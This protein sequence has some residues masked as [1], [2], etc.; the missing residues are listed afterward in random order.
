MTTRI[1]TIV[2]ASTAAIFV[3]S[4][5]FSLKRS[6]KKKD[7]SIG[8]DFVGIRL[9]YFPRSPCARRIWLLLKLR[10]IKFQGIV[11]DLMKGE[12]RNATYLQLNPLGEVPV[13]VHRK[14]QGGPLII[15]YESAAIAAYIENEFGGGLWD[16]D[17]EQFIQFELAIAEIVW[18]LS[19]AQVDGVIWRFR[20]SRAAFF[21]KYRQNTYHHAKVR[22]IYEAKH[23][24]FQDRRHRMRRCAQ[25][26]K[27]LDMA[28]GHNLFFRLQIQKKITYAH[29]SLYSRLIKI[30]QNG[31]FLKK[32]AFPQLT[33][34]LESCIPLFNN[35]G[36]AIWNSHGRPTF[37]A[38][39]IGFLFAYLLSWDLLVRIGNWRAGVDF[40]RVTQDD[41]F[42]G[43]LHQ[44]EVM[45]LQAIPR[46]YCLLSKPRLY[47]DAGHTLAAA[48]LAL[49]QQDSNIEF[50]RVDT[51]RLQHELDPMIRQVTPL[52]ELPALTTS[53]GDGYYG[54][55]VVLRALGEDYI[56][57]RER[58]I[59][60]WARTA[61]FYQIAPLKRWT[62]DQ[63]ILDKLAGDL[64]HS[65]YLLKVWGVEESQENV[66]ACAQLCSS[67]NEALLRG[68]A[69]ELWTSC[70]DTAAQLVESSSCA[71]VNAFVLPVV[72]LACVYAK[73]ILQ[74]GNNS[75][76]WLDLLAYRSPKLSVWAHK[77]L[78][79]NKFLQIAIGDLI[80][81]HT[82]LTSIPCRLGGEGPRGALIHN[83]PHPPFIRQDVV[84][85]LQ[86]TFQPE[87]SDIY[88]VT[89]PKAGTTW[90]QQIIL[91]LL[92]NGDA[93]KVDPHPKIQSQAP[94]LEACYC[95][96][97][98]WG[99]PC[100]YLDAHS[101][102][103][104]HAGRRVFK[105]HAPEEL[106][107][108][109]NKLN[110]GK[111][112]YVARNAKDTCCSL[113]SHCKTLPP[114]EYKESIDHFVPLFCQ[115]LVEHGSWRSHHLGWFNK[116]A[117]QENDNDI[118]YIHFEFLKENPNKAITR[119]A[120]FIGISHPS[121]ELIRAVVHH[122]SFAAMKQRTSSTSV[123]TLYQASTST[124][125][126]TSRFRSGAVGKWHVDNG[127]LL[128]ESHSALIDSTLL[129]D[130]PTGLLF[131]SSS[132]QHQEEE[133]SG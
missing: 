89:F 44:V 19:R 118:L 106:A 75:S 46:S 124:N 105:S 122:S 42:Q 32:N 52:G 17:L 70:I 127:G 79:E 13:L 51:A 60:G 84:D 45:P 116:A 16:F 93:T 28:C 10:N 123:S 29:L 4:S 61:W 91:L 104:R 69:T 126:A 31:L 58:Q 2:T 65:A 34:Y 115:G 14:V 87:S 66:D 131:S 36:K 48:V 59:I 71:I 120:Q 47:Y 55:T 92:H 133:G 35:W 112:I 117:A 107:I 64:S 56:G 103:P 73:K 95:R 9:Y 3:L 68:C 83:I 80:L 113:Y 108:F 18:P 41:S 78:A 23:C 96:T 24:S 67:T 25:A 109:R 43:A 98:R 1:T 129:Y 94:W 77:A 99:G 30:P 88:I 82:A 76:H 8:E 37:L 12:Q 111:T 101:T 33:T 72:A 86:N 85:Y 20:E 53:R 7:F 62:I 15:I 132:S 90:M 27:M 128:T 11:V 39:E 26:L 63:P 5:W 38:R 125:F 54:A 100:P 110:R 97:P 102:L 57:V 22:A 130:L 114:Y 74:N 119:I 21:R 50:I 6:R 121:D 40:K 49:V 81:A